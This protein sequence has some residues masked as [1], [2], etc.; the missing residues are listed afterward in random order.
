M[1]EDGD[2]GYENLL[3]PPQQVVRIDVDGNNI[4]VVL[5]NS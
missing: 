4:Q 2:T 3:V 5:S 1:S